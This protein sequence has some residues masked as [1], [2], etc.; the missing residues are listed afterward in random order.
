MVRPA[1]GLEATLVADEVPAGGGNGWV[2]R[3]LDPPPFPGSFLSMALALILIGLLVMLLLHFTLG[4][5]LVVIGI[6]LLFV[7]GVPYGYHGRRGPP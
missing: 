5:I 4:L 2:D 1:Q 7:P 3:A 6:V